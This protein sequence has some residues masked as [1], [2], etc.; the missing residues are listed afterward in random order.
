MSYKENGT[1]N[2]R[3]IWSILSNSSTIDTDTQNLT[4]NNVVDSFNI[5]IGKEMVE[6]RNI[7]KTMGYAIPVQLHIV[8]KLQK[9]GSEKDIGIELKYEE[10]DPSGNMLSSSNSHKIDFKRQFKYIRWRTIFTPLLVNEGG[11]Y[12]IRVLLK[13]T[14]DQ[15]FTEVDMIPLT[16]NLAEAEKIIGT[17]Q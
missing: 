6:K 12:F 10:V 15:D 5:D 7:E 8:T 14:G 4:I 9:K 17:I 1:E 16:I 3:Y 2:V 13:E 11:D